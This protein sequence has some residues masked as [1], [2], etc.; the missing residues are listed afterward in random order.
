MS[1]VS[2]Q[3]T[4]NVEASRFS[5]DRAISGRQWKGD[6]EELLIYTTALSDEQVESVEGYLAHKW[7]LAA[8]LPATHN[9]ALGNAIDFHYVSNNGNL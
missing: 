3:T 5:D 9:Y 1:I 7:G 6:L 8:K 4:G 2:L